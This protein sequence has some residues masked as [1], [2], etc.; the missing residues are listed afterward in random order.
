MTPVRHSAATAAIIP[1]HL[2]VTAMR[3][4]GYKNT[5]YALAELIDNS[6]QAKASTVELLCLE[7][8]ELVST[9]QRRRLHQM[10]VVDDGTGMDEQTLRMA[11]QFGN[12]SRLDDRS[13]IGRFGMGLP[14]AS[15]SQARRVDV[16][17]WQNGPE[18]ALHTFI[19]LDDIETGEMHDVPLPRRAAIPGDW[20]D[21]ST[22]I[23]RS[24]TVVVW[25]KLD[26]QRLTWKSAKLTL[27]NTERIVGRVHRRFIADERVSIRLFATADEAG[28]PLVDYAAAVNDPLYLTPSPTMAKPFDQKAMFTE[29]FSYPLPVDYGDKQHHVVLTFSVATTDTVSEA[30]NAGVRDRGR[31]KYGKHA[32]QNMGVSVIRSDREITLDR[33][34]CIGY[35]PRERWWGAE[36]EFPPALDELFGLTNNKQAVNHFS[37][38]AALEWQQLSEDGE[39]FRDVV[40]RLKE[41][42]DPRGWLLEISD[43]IQRNLGQLRETI[44][45]QGVRRP[46][47]KKQRHDEPDDATK[48]V[49]AKWKERSQEKPIPD[50]R[51][52]RTPDDLREIEEDLT[53]NKGYSEDEAKELV[54]MIEDAKLNV[55]FLEADFPNS[56]EL[57]NVELKGAVTEITFNRKH[58]AFADIFGTV[59]T[60]DRDLADLTAGEVIETVRR[61]VNSTKITFAAWARYEREAG[62]KKAEQLRKVRFDWG[63]IAAQFLL[64]EEEWE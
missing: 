16:W 33:S 37:A 35:D 7:R 24:G 8:F 45:A 20:L 48:E 53:K 19:D 6:V 60:A 4:S 9:R 27:E 63:Q 41:D 61:A 44:K 59:A 46:H 26:H 14:S 56:Y 21:L 32:M 51:T 58:P 64:P 18:N 54:T 28:T 47:G 23:G 62:I 17:S 22:G 52:Q 55:L 31:T 12:G 36:I 30:V 39:E 34:W 11:L 1:A 50:E 43:E 29:V 10:A 3:D 5:A 15:I 40:R 57:F 13:G 2:A 25:S 42:E 49:N 38:V